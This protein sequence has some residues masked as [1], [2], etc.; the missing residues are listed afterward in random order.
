MSDSLVFEVALSQSY[1]D[2]MKT[3][4]TAL[5]AEGFG[6]LTHV[7]VRNTFKEKLDVDF[8]P[9]SILGFC[10]PS[11]AHRILT[12]EPRIGLVLPCKVTV[13]AAEDNTSIVRFINPVMILKLEL[14]DDPAVPALAH[15]VEE[16]IRRVVGALENLQG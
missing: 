14:G 16:I 8:R 5:N 4:E 10:N 1:E 11:Y 7:N 6:I 9:Y 2:A 13:E 12:V 15:E 3:V